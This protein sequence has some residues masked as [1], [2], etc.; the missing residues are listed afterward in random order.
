MDEIARCLSDMQADRR[1][2]FALPIS[3]AGAFRAQS[4]AFQL[5]SLEPNPCPTSSSSMLADKQQNSV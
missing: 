4:L 2:A 3:V 1:S 5:P